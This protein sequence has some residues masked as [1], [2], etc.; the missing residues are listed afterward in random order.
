MSQLEPGEWQQVEELFHRLNLLG[1]DEQKAA[2]KKAEAQYSPQ[3]IA[4]AGRLL[5]TDGNMDPNFL[6]GNLRKQALQAMGR[7]V[8]Q[9]SR[10]E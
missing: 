7:R 1:E 8:S 2:L 5:D 6:E 9:H 3:V 10:T 4:E